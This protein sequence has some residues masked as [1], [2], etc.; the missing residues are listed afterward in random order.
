MKA[1][2]K[3]G[4]G[5]FV[6]AAVLGIRVVSVERLDDSSQIAGDGRVADT[7]PIDRVEIA[8]DEAA[9]EA[10]ESSMRQVMTGMRER[11]P[12]SASAEARPG[13]RMVSCRLRG[14]TQFMT[15][16]DCA[17]RGG[18]STIFESDR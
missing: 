5:L 6:V 15:A 9:R 18:H 8:K 3:M 11:L 4:I 1:G 14:T 2:L 7:R 17:M 12:G 10:D 13:D 16:D